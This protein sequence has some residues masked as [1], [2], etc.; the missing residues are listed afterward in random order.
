MRLVCKIATFSI[1]IEVFLSNPSVDIFLGRAH[2]I[3][4]AAETIIGSISTLFSC[5][6]CL[7]FE[8]LFLFLHVRG[9][10]EIHCITHKV[11]CWEISTGTWAEGVKS[12]RLRI[13]YEEFSQFGLCCACRLFM[14]INLRVPSCLGGGYWTW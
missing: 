12:R 9:N 8:T 2:G 10:W 4:P 6:I 11:Q 13:I 14:S 7:S 3:R 5:H 1:S